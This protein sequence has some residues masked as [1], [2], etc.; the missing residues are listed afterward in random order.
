M[1]RR[2][3]TSPAAAR[4]AGDP[5]YLPRMW[6]KRRIAALLRDKLDDVPCAGDPCPSPEELRE[7]HRE[8]L[9]KEIVALGN[10]Y[11][12]LS[13]HTSLL[14]LEN[15]A[16][17][18]R[19]GV[20][21][22]RPAE[23]APYH[24]PAT[25]QVPPR[26]PARRALAAGTAQAVLVRTPQPVFYRQ[27]QQAMLESTDGWWSGP[28][29]Q[30]MGGFA[31]PGA[32]RDW[33]VTRGRAPRTTAPLGRLGR[34]TATSTPPNRETLFEA[35]RRRRPRTRASRCRRRPAPRRRPTSRHSRRWPTTQRGPRRGH[36]DHH[37]P[38]A[39]RL[40]HHRPR[41]RRRR[42]RR[43]ATAGAGA[44][45]RAG[46]ARA[47]SAR[48]PS[49][50]YGGLGL[51]PMQAGQLAPISMASPS[52]PRLDDLT[53]QVPGF[54]PGPFDAA[55]GELHRAGH[56]KHGSI[57]P[58]AR[59]LLDAA[60]RQIKPGAYRWGDGPEVTVDA[61]GRL[62]WRVRDDS[63]LDEL[64]SYDGTTWRRAYPELGL[65]LVR[66]IGDDEPALY[67]TVLPVL[68]ASPDHLARWYD[69][70]AAGQTVTLKPATGKGT[71]ITIDLDGQGRVVALR[72]GGDD[73]TITLGRRRPDRGPARRAARSRSRI[74]RPPPPTPTAQLRADAGALVAVDLPLHTPAYWRTRLATM[75]AGSDPWRHG[76]RQLLAALAALARP[77]RP[78]DRV[79][80]AARPRRD[81]RRRRRP[82]QPRPRDRDHRRP[83]RPTRWPTSPTAPARWPATWRRRGATASTRAPACSA[84]SPATAWSA[85]WPATAASSPAS[86]PARPTAPI[87]ALRAMGDRAPTLRLIA[88]STLSNRYMYQRTHADEIAAGLGRGRHRPVAQRRPLRGGPRALLPRRLRRRRRP[89]RRAPRRRRPRR[90]ADPVGR[91]RD[92]RDAAEPARPGRLAAGVG[93]LEGQGPR[94]RRPRPR[95]RPGPGRGQRRRRATSIACSVGPPTSPP[96]TATRPPQ[97]AGLALAYGQLDRA[98]ALIDDARKLAPSPFLDRLAAQIAERQGRPAAAAAMLSKA[99][100]SATGPTS[101]SQVRADYGHL[102]QLQGRVAALATGA[103]RDHAVANLLDA[104]AAWRDIDPDDDGREQAVAQQLLAAGRHAEAMRVLSTVI[105]RHPMEGT[106]WAMVAESLERE[107]RLAEARDYWHQAVVIDQ[108]NPQWRLRDAQVLLALGRGDDA[109]AELAEITHRHWHS[110]WGM[111]V[112]QVRGMLARLDAERAKTGK[113]ATRPGPRLD[114]ARAGGARSAVAAAPSAADLELAF[115]ERFLL[116]RG[117]E[118]YPVQEQ[119]IA[120]IVAGKSV[121]VTV[122]TGTG[123]T[124]MAKAALF[125][126]LE[127]GQRAVY[128]TPLRALTEEKYR[129]L[130]ADFGEDKVGFATGDY[131]VNR[132]APIQV[133]VAE[134]L[135]N[136][137]FG[138]KN[139]L[140]ADVVVMDEG[141][142]FNDPERGYVWEQSIIGLDPRVQ[143]VILSATVGRPDKFVHWVEL[144][145]R[146]SMQL[147]ESRERKVPLVH[148]YREETLID[149]VKQLVH[150]GDV[151]AIIFVF[152]RELCFEVA[153]LLKSCRRFTSDE[154]RAEVDRLCD[155]ALLG[156]GAR[157]GAAA[158]PVARHRHPPR[159][160]PAPLQAAGRGAGPGPAD[161]ARGLDRD[162]R[163]RDQ[164]AGAHG[165]VPVAAQV[166]QEAGPAGDRGRVPPDG[167]SGR[168]AAVRRQGPGDRAGARGAW[169]ATSRRS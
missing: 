78:V 66:P 95:A 158:A 30:P 115:Y 137:I 148:D 17:Y 112:E 135:W 96:A 154:E 138:D 5:G 60:R 94:R 4:P 162:H 151:P 43:G 108:T 81:R 152:G 58:A 111:V 6:A 97:V 44:R 90:R 54:F 85:R 161:Q 99:L 160:H 10:R 9:R 27:D 80:G 167:G 82:G 139:V 166:H 109:R 131:K 168:A 38:R 110:R 92:L 101:L 91:H 114:G 169:S 106:G 52:D 136:R 32:G 19:Y 21:R 117:L 83:A 100:A 2:G 70:T 67:G 31:G 126:A 65:E 116:S 39:R 127:R 86:P 98:A 103:D 72:A 50:K 77:R 53:D 156:S 73:V 125:A 145:R 40:R 18:A 150:D 129:E 68:L 69:V 164:P 25:I 155:E 143:L 62:G 146:V 7:A 93:G 122:P 121:M 120:P 34:G 147:I 159:R 29:A 46:P 153:R 16:M 33:V 118:P 107:G 55:A 165:H 22:T 12:L 11:F 24:L 13:R 130:A 59:A 84:R 123:K 119:A 1:V 48:T 20:P 3:S 61:A 149:T 71:A 88:A 105:E 113:A 56:G 142:Y 42:H 76:Q 28:T 23:W 134:I 64:D 37:R 63:G 26:P 74:R 14:V 104:A 75:T 144:T 102:I 51:G 35:E 157:Q 133:E 49:Y 132:D 87:D 128:T 8:T 140:P 124:L 163:G 89:V 47:C 41:R 57:D 79:P 15:D 141:H 45:P 36:R